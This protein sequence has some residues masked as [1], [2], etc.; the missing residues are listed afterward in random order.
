MDL[1]FQT[2]NTVNGKGTF[3]VRLKQGLYIHF[4]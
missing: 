3:S 1:L 2:F 4:R